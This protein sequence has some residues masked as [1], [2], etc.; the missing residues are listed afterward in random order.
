MFQTQIFPTSFL[1][2]VSGRMLIGMGLMKLGVFSAGRSRRYYWVLMLLGYGLGLPL[3]AFGGYQL[4]RRHFDVVYLFGTG[5]AYNSLGS[6]PVALGHVAVLL[7]VYK[8]GLLT[9]LT[10]RL[11]AVGRMA[12][13]NYL[14]QSILCTTLFY[15]YGLGLYGTLD[16]VQLLGVVVGVWLLQLW[17]SPLWLRHFRYGPVEW[18][19]RSLT[20]GGLQPLRVLEPA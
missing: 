13:S 2:S 4:I 8:A 3:V 20:Y 10:R 15:G 16:R 7:L 12:L 14:M 1:W 9:G 17:Y 5:L 6:I 19:W 18:L 11:A